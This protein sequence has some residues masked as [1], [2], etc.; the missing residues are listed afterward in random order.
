M[1]SFHNEKVNNN[2]ER[3]SHR[4]SLCIQV[5][6]EVFL[7]EEILL[8]QQTVYVIEK[9]SRKISK[10]DVFYFQLSENLYFRAVAK[11]RD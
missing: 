3:N 11:F 6:V 5:V 8:V 1:E 10:F 4:L 2:T 7:K 9:Y